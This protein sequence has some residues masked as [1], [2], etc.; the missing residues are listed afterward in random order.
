MNMS[1]VQ[2]REGCTA[3]ITGSSNYRLNAKVFANNS[4][5]ATG[6]SA[7]EIIEI[8]NNVIMLTKDD[9]ASDKNL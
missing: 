7:S 4:I 9:R 1:W 3:I 6:L 2:L 8:L 5:R